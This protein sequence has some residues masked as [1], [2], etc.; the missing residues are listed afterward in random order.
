MDIGI[1]ESINDYLKLIQQNYD[2]FER[3]YLFGSYVKGKQ[4]IDSDIDLALIFRHLD[5]SDRFDVQVQLMLLAAQID[6]RIEPHPISSTDFNA[7]N[8]FVNEIKKTGVEI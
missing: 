1:N 4:G 7:G 2:E 8:P 3:A 5:D 6:S